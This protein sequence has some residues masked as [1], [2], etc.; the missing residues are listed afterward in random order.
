MYI[1][2]W[3]QLSF[4][5][6]CYIAHI[7]L[8]IV[9]P[10]LSVVIV[11]RVPS[12]LNLCQLPRVDYIHVR[13]HIPFQTVNY[14]RRKRDRHCYC[15][16]NRKGRWRRSHSRSQSRSPRV[17]SGRWDVKSRVE[18]PSQ[19]VDSEIYDGK[20]SSI[21][22]FGC[23]VQLEGVCGRHEGLVHVSQLSS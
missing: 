1:V 15:S 3:R 10:T 23:F 14:Q 2:N 13:K 11:R 4:N 19:P 5:N 17:G 9:T 12:K 6:C 7:K 8:K 21:M 20:V 18:K 16:N 22:Q